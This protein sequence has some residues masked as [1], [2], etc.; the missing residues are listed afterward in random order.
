M[1]LQSTVRTNYSP[2]VQKTAHWILRTLGWT[3]MG[4]RPPHNR[5]VITAV[6][7]TTNWDLFYM[8]MVSLAL[9]IPAVFTL[10]DTWFFWPLG[11]LFR[12]MGGI[13]INRRE[14]T[15]LV[16]QIIEA[17]EHYDDMYLVITPEGTRKEVK[18]WKTGYYWIA[19]GADAA[20]LPAFINYENKFTGVADEP[21]EVTGDFEADFQAIAAFYESKV[22]VK[23]AYDPARL[24]EAARKDRERDAS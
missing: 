3:L 17:F 9:N 1:A 14:S 6:P 19:K 16:D 23:P 4:K 12:W 24:P 2:R 8:L 15:N 11:P 13:P 10:K 21:F 22:G 18:H 7:H 20:I 5:L